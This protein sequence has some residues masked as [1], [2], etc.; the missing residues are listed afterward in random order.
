[1]DILAVELSKREDELLQQKTEITKI[2]AT[3]KLV[4]FKF[5]IS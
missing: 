5:L 1:V 2:A 4:S 3:L